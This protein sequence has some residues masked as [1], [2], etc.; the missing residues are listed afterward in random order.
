MKPR[1]FIG[2]STESAA[3]AHAIQ[4]ELDRDAEC[5]VWTQGVFGLSDT[6]VRSLIEEARRSDYAI[7]VMTPDDEANVRGEAFSIPRDNVIYELGLFSGA[8]GPE[9]CFLI[10]PRG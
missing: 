7:F 8:V 4:A 2:S 10:T 6:P 9:R 3:V 1:I 5:T